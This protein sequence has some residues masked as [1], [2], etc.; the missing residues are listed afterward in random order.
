MLRNL[1][2]DYS[3]D[4]A[5]L[6]T[7]RVSFEFEMQSLEACSAVN[8]QRVFVAPCMESCE[9]VD[10]LTGQGFFSRFDFVYLPIDFKNSVGL[11][12][13]F[14]NM[15]SPGPRRKPI[16]GRFRSPH[17]VPPRFARVI[18]R[19]AIK[20]RCKSSSACLASGSGRSSARRPATHRIT[21]PHVAAS[22]IALRFLARS[23]KLPGEIQSNLNG[24]GKS[25]VRVRVLR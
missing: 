15:V 21:S 13:A 11:G 23:V 8:Q 1:P 17:V 9:V 20:M 12:Y 7:S 5:P 10:L 6:L 16:S 18:S 19:K 22:G 3:R 2:N 25:V 24:F 4:D 14:I